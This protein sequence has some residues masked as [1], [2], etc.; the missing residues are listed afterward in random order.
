MQLPQLGS[1]LCGACRGGGALLLQPTAQAS[2]EAATVHAV[3][4]GRGPAILAQEPVLGA[5]KCDGFV[6]P[7][8][9]VGIYMNI[10]LFARQSLH[11]TE[12]R[13]CSL[14]TLSYGAS[15]EG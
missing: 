3:E 2:M 8:S 1:P 4:I 9:L 6:P 10:H 13:R 14:Y 11:E 7:L 5:W 12:K 15:S